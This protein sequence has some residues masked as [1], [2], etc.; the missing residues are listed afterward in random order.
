MESLEIIKA[1]GHA[2]I[3]GAHKTTIEITKDKDLTLRGECIIGIKADK[4]CSDLN[5]KLKQEIRKESKFKVVIK[6][7]DI[8][9]TFY[10]WG[11]KDLKLINSRDIVFRKS[12]FICDRTILINCTK[13]SQ[14]L[15][16]IL[17]EKLKNENQLIEMT[18]E[19][20]D[21]E[22]NIHYL[23]I[24][25]E[26]SNSIKKLFSKKKI[27]EK[28]YRILRNQD[29]V[30]F[31][32]KEDIYTQE[33]I[34]KI[35][36][37]KPFMEIIVSKPIINE[38][39]KFKDIIGELKNKLDSNYLYLIPRSF[40]IIGSK[41]SKRFAIIEFPESTD[42]EIE[43]LD[44][45]K[46]T[47]AIALLNVNKSIN[48]VFEKKSEREG[49]YRTRRLKLL[50]GEERS[51]TIHK[52]NNCF[53]KL[54]IK[55]VFFSPRLVHER[56]RITHSGINEN[57]IVLDLFAGVGSFSI[58]IAKK[59]NSRIF[60]M[61]INPDAIKYLEENI[62]INKVE[63]KITCFL[64]DVKNLLNKNNDLGKRLKNKMDRIIM[65]LPKNS[66]DYLEVACNMIKKK[67]GI[68]HF[69][70]ISGE[71]YP[72]KNINTKFKLKLEELNFN[73]EKVLTTKIVKTYSPYKYL[74]VMDVKIK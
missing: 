8:S 35:I 22:E 57:N 11:H 73:I 41:K 3:L 59:C 13:S 51:E 10:G 62:K 64:M 18:I 2:N 56:Q 69:Y 33:K 55:K 32:L 44:Q 54:D 16:R 46:K 45:I 39:Y 34:I 15:S 25:R 29:Y 23:K 4:A 26:K 42:I 14:D 68:I 52:E 63:D 65:N 1:F 71:P 7:N 28:K 47:I 61:D 66:I 9:E 6:L 60:A 53:F 19:L 72:L 24:E 50:A 27:I 74:T 36:E 20:S 12:N 43:K 70:S 48:S 67:E 5:I 49:T 40:D 21:E 30:L 31:P 37:Q 38:K 58:Q 17:I